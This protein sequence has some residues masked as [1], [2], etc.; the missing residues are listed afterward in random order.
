MAT[1][2]VLRGGVRGSGFLHSRK[3]LIDTGGM[4]LPAALLLDHGGPSSPGTGAANLLLNSMYDQK[5]KTSEENYEHAMCVSKV[6]M[7]KTD[8]TNAEQIIINEI[9]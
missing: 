7:T 5:K 8:F 4:I 3:L 2:S 1:S 6:Y 9:N